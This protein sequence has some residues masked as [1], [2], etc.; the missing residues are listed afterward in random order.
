ML[1][2][3]EPARIASSRSGRAPSS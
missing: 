2:V 3:P 1:G